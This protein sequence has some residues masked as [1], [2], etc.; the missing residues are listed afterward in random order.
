[1]GR[2]KK[3]FIAR[4]GVAPGQARDARARTWRFVFDCYERKQQAVAADSREED[5]R[6]DDDVSGKPSA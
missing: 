4:S 2:Q 5:T 3:T 1:M 6:K